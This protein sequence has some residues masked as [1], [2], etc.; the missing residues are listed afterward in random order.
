LV[1]AKQDTSYKPD[2]S[3]IEYLNMEKMYDSTY[4]KNWGVA[5]KSKI[6]EYKKLLQ[7]LKTNS[8]KRP[9]KIIAFGAAA[10]GCIFLNASEIDYKL[11]DFIIDDTDIKQ[12]KYMPGTGIEIVS[13]NS[14]NFSDVD[15][16]LIL[17]HNFAEHI[18]KSIREDSSLNFHGK[19]ITFLP[20]FQI[21]E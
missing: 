20:K 5:I 15:Y 21:Y 2:S 14:V 19:F 9:A 3:I 11:I 17:T 10:K 18:S 16:I 13:R 12:N 4:Y 8:I 7:N 1:M 6:G